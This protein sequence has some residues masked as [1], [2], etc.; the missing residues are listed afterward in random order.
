MST[1]DR[2]ARLAQAGQW[3]RANRQKRGYARQVEFATALGVDNSVLSNYERGVSQVDDERAAQIA[4][5]L[6]MDEIEVRQGLGLW[7]PSDGM[8]TQQD[9]ERVPLHDLINWGM[10]IARRY[11]RDQAIQQSARLLAMLAA[12][13]DEG[14]E[15]TG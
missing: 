10:E 12:Q 9:L 13:S 5:L 7:V 4:R 1:A 14:S 2:R 15:M 3:L 8:P 6:D 11:P